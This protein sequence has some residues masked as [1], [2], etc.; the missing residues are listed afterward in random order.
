MIGTRIKALRKERGWSLQELADRIGSGNSYVWEIENKKRRPG[1]DL[2]INF[3]KAF[4][5]SI[6]FLALGEAPKDDECRAVLAELIANQWQP[7]GLSMEYGK[8]LIDKLEKT[9]HKRPPTKGGNHDK[10]I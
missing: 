5:V 2:M 4:N 7:L 6:D 10:E 1:I 9:S 3:S 8:Q